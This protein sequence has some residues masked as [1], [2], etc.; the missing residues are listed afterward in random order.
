MSLKDDILNTIDDPKAFTN[1][2]SKLVHL[3]TVL[4]TQQSLRS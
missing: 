2:V 3:P 4:L 1:Q